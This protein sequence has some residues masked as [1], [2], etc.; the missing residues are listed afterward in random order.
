MTSQILEEVAAGEEEVGV[1]DLKSRGM[2]V[3]NSMEKNYV[4]LNVMVEKVWDSEDEV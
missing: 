3:K 4:S 2:W 1:N